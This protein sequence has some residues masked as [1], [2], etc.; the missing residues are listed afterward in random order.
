MR[1]IYKYISQ[2]KLNYILVISTYNKYIMIET[3]VYR[4]TSFEVGTSYLFALYTRIEGRY[5]NQRYFTTNELQ[6]VGKY[7]RSERWGHGDGGGGAEIFDDN[8]N[9]VRI[10]YTYEGTTCFKKIEQHG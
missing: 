4:L 10:V 6:S 5:P 8:G 9:E 7:I 1:N 2:K 3:E